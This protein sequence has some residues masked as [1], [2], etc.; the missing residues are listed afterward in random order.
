MEITIGLR[1]V[2]REITLNVD[3]EAEEVRTAIAAAIQ[4][5]APLITLADKQGRTVIIPTAAL[6]YVEIG[7]GRSHRVGFGA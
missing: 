7:S 3:Q 4:E 1:Q 6:A 5:E 2:A